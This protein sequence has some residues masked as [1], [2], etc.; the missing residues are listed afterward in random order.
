MKVRVRD[1]RGG[2]KV[3]VR[4]DLGQRCGFGVAFDGRGECESRGD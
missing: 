3:W 4:D 1:D 2:M